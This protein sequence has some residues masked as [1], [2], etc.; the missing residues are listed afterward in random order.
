MAY[1]YMHKN[2]PASKLTEMLNELGSDGWKVVK[3]DPPPAGIF[4]QAEALYTVLL[5][6]KKLVSEK[7]LLKG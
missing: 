7:Q 3:C 4:N 6:R 1:E 5:E 2:I